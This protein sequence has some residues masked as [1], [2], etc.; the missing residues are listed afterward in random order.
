[1]PARDSIPGY[2][3]ATSRFYRQEAGVDYRSFA[4]KHW[5]KFF[6]SGL[7]ACGYGSLEFFSGKVAYPN[8][9]DDPI[10]APYFIFLGFVAMTVGILLRGRAGE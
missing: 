10:Y 7:L 9:L 2:R 3:R 6:L 5:R 1:M 4:Q 8:L